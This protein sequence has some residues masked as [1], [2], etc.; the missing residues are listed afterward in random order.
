VFRGWTACARGEIVCTPVA[1]TA[2]DMGV[3]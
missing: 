3:W 1:V 2:I